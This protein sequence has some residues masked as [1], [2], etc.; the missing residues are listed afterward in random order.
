MHF[1]A[2][3]GS[4]TTFDAEGK[5]AMSA[6]VYTNASTKPAFEL[7]TK[8]VYDLSEVVM[9]TPVPGTQPAFRPALKRRP[10]VEERPTHPVLQARKLVRAVRVAPVPATVAA[11]APAPAATDWAVLVPGTPPASQAAATA[12]AADAAGPRGSAFVPESPV[13]H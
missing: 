8:P 5:E 12:M 9:A 2:E 4:F 7:G 1:R 10:V 11:P 6:K 3:L 13:L